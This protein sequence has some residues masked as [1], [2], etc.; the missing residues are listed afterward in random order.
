LK[1]RVEVNIRGHEYVI[2]SS[3]SEAEIQRVAAFVDE[4]V[5]G[6]TASGATV[7]SL[8]ATILAFM[9]VAGLY[10]DLQEKVAQ[11]EDA[12]QRITEL[13]QKLEDALK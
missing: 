9:N 3:R 13:N 8:H 4:K 1:Q 2:R 11:D 7:D 12:A 5:N 10:L 6:V